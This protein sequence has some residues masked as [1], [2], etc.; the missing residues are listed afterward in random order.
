MTFLPMSAIEMRD[1]GWDQC[2]IILV[3]GDAYVDHPSFGAAVIGRVLELGGFR[4]GIIAQPDWR[5]IA[6][7]TKLGKP[8]L[9]FG[10]TSGNIDSML[11]HYTAARKL[12][13]DDPYSP[14]GRPGLRPNRASIVYSNRLREAYKDVPIVL[15]GIEASLRRLAHYDYWND[16]VRR[17]ILFDAKADILVYGMGE[18]AIRSIAG[19]LNTEDGLQ[20]TQLRSVPGTASVLGSRDVEKV[21]SS[22]CIKL[23][24]FEEVSSSK[25]AFNRAFAL[26]T[27]E[28]NPYFGKRLLQ[29]HGDR[30]LIVN[31]PALPLATEE[32]D[33][34]YELPYEHKAHPAYKEPIPALETVKWSIVSHRGCYGGCSFCTLYFHQGPIVQSRSIRSVIREVRTLSARKDFKGTIADIGGPTAN[35]YGTNCKSNK[36]GHDC[37]RRS[38]LSPRMCDNLKTDQFESI[39]LWRA[40][41]DIPGVKQMFVASGVRHDLALRDPRYL[42]N[43][44]QERTG[45]HLKIAPE[46]TSPRVLRLMN[47]PESDQFAEFVDAFRHFSNKEQ[48]LVPYLI[49]S[50]PGC[51]TEDMA[52]L[53][54]FLQERRIKVEQV[55]DFI[56]LPMTASA[57]MYHTGK[58]PF[59]GRNVYVER[60]PAGKQNQRKML[61]MPGDGE[62]ELS[63]RRDGQSDYRK[64]RRFPAVTK[65]ISNF[66]ANRR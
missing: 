16:A 65:K 5:G 49:S 56:P 63:D 13:R 38:C 30:Y 33:R 22:D 64:Y 58:D 39:K 1:R 54:E 24:S 35:M 20:N 32:L 25:E 40:V 9:F 43:L 34:I 3:T 14:G 27:N 15:G 10:V 66:K 48:Y 52:E 51:G 7:F 47:K 17:S 21:R 11:H 41:Q 36:R 46:H 42:K 61:S 31:P 55:Q 53:R 4:V 62:W 2:D 60:T 50:H 45:G 29:Q 26:T 8:R 12:R 59:T 28:A 44:I 18:G 6:D 37:R 23:P 19:M 57:A